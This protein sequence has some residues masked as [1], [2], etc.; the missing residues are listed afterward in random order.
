M[1][2]LL[3]WLPDA[4]L[5]A[6]LVELVNLCVDLRLLFLDKEEFLQL[7]VV[8]GQVLKI[9]HGVY[10]M[11]NFNKSLGI[12]ILCLTNGEAVNCDHF[13]I[14]ST[15]FNYKKQLLSDM[16]LLKLKEERKLAS[17]SRSLDTHAFCKI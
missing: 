15:L 10:L 5:P 4:L 13:Y 1:V 6:N 8:G 16:S 9:G 12:F 7:F 11:N 3:A 17:V 2:Q 14:P